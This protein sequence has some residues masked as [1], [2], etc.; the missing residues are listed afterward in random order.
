MGLAIETGEKVAGTRRI[1]SGLCLPLSIQSLWK[2]RTKF[3]VQEVGIQNEC[4]EDE[5]EKTGL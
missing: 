2:K 4:F 1:S 5:E 3:R